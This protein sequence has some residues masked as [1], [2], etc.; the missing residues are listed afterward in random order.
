MC[1]RID[2]DNA[3]AIDSRNDNDSD[4]ASDNGNDKMR[5]AMIM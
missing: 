4:Y 1:D 5:R 3:K 2:S